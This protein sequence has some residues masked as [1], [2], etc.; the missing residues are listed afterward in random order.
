MKR[1]PLAIV[2]LVAGIMLVIPVILFFII[3]GL[4]LGEAHPLAVVA[5]PL[6]MLLTLPEAPLQMM[7]VPIGFP[8]ILP[9]IS[10][11]TGLASVLR[12]E[13][14]KNLAIAGMILTV[15]SLVGLLA[16]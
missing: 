2:S 1:S 16:L 8:V 7:N 14:K 6:V 5:F 15:L 12:T 3:D 4:G 11:L 10:L 13:P 9:A